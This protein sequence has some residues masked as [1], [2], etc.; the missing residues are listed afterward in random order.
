MNIHTADHYFQ[1]LKRHRDN[2]LNDILMVVM[3]EIYSFGPQLK[4]QS[5]GKFTVSPT[6]WHNQGALTVTHVMFFT[7]W[8]IVLCVT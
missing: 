7:Y 4:L 8:K 2:I 1:C 5:M 3:S 6:V